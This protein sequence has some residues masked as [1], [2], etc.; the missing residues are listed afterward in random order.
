MML[1]LNTSG[2]L[3]ADL[4]FLATGALFLD[5]FGDRKFGR[6]IP[7]LAVMT[8]DFGVLGCVSLLIAADCLRFD[9]NNLCCRAFFRFS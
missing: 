5:G 1:G 6:G 2:F 8:D 4:G 7:D 3:I 9:P